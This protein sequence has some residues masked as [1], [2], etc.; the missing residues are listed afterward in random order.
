MIIV[1]F[2]DNEAESGGYLAAG[3]GFFNINAEGGAEPCSFSP[4]SDTSLKT[5]LEYCY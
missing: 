2:R 1:S 5:L 4:Y 3:R